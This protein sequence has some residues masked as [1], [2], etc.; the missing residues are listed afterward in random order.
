MKR[1]QFMVDTSAD[2]PDEL[3]K[4]YDIA[5][6]NF[7]INFG[8]ESYIA[9]EEMSNAEFYKRMAE[10]PIMPKTAQTPFQTM[11]DA[12][13][14]NAKTCETLIYYTISSKAS[15]QF[16]TATLIS[17]EL[18]EENPELDI[19]IVDTQNFSYF[20]TIALEKAI[21]LANE[22]KSPDDIIRESLEYMNR[23]DVFFVVDDL[24]YLQKGGRIKK[25]TAAIGTMLDIKPVLGVNDGLIES[26]TTIRGK[27]KVCRKLIALLDETEG[28][29][30]DTT[31]FVVLHSGIEGGI[32]LR[33]ALTDAYG[34]D[35]IRIMHELS[36][37]IGTHTGPGVK[38][39]IYR[40]N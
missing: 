3:I 8:E 16:Q 7:M 6:I 33:D 11:Y 40:K 2:M 20:I 10:G 26:L 1:I 36:A 13:L 38:A 14:E 37:L 28:F 39:V 17:K 5:E 35:K 12:I 24:S 27:K 32:E 25:S 4:K 21:E 34:E 19:R 30:P 22:G 18:M 23:Y 31:E 9:K 29:N 15:G